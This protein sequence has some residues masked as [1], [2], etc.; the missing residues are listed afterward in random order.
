MLA[1]TLLGCSPIGVDVESS[2]ASVAPSGPVP[3]LPTDEPAAAPSGEPIAVVGYGTHGEMPCQ[4]Q[5]AEGLLRADVEL[6]DRLTGAPERNPITIEIWP[7][8]TVEWPSGVAAERFLS[9]RWPLE[10][11]GLRLLGGEVAC[12]T[13]RV[14]LL[15]RRA[16]NTDSLA[17]GPWLQPS[18]GPLFGAGPWVDAFNVCR[19]SE[20]VIPKEG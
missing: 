12:W 3:A 6:Q 14:S 8:D 17:N 15:R 19:G 18:G 11:T 16:G 4:D 9:V 2:A 7:L 13:V 10:Y 20:F 1:L 5:W